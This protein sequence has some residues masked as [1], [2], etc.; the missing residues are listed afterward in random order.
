MDWGAV[1]G[2]RNLFLLPTSASASL[3]RSGRCSGLPTCITRRNFVNRLDTWNVIGIKGTAKRE[4]E[5]DVFGEGKFDFL[6]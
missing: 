6:T 3:G 1:L 2:A 5:M 4:E